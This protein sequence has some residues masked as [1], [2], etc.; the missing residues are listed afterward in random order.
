MIIIIWALQRFSSEEGTEM[1]VEGVF[2][3]TPTNEQCSIWYDSMVSDMDG[4]VVP[5]C[6]K[7]DV[8]PLVVIFSSSPM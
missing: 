8:Q 3:T 6:D 5:R 1:V 7:E 2:E 4:M